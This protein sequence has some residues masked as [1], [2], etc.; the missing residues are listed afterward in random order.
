MAATLAQQYSLAYD[1]AF[2][3]RVAMA[4]VA[5]AYTVDQELASV[6]SHA[7]RLTLANKVVGGSAVY[8]PQFAALIATVDA[9]VG[10]SYA[11]TN[12][13]SQANVAD[14]SIASDVA[15]G[16]NLVAGV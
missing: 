2:I 6:V 10:T 12:P 9:S 1:T 8:A 4:V 11:S 13:A 16:W 7:A 5:Y 15:I 14:A 3:Q